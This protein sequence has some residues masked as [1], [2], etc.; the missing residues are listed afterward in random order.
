M[1]HIR[2]FS[3]IAHI[4]HGKSTLSDRLIQVCGG[5][6][7]REMAAQVLDSM[8]LERERGITIKS[9]SVTLN[10]TAKDGETYQ[11]N[12]IDTPGHV[13]FAYEVSRS[14]AACEGALLVVDAGQGVEAQTLANC[15]TAIEMDLEVVPILNKIDLP[16]AD[17]E[18][19]AEEI[20][21]IVGIDAMDATHCSAKT[22]LGVEDVLENIVSAIPAPEGDPDAPLQALIIDSWFDNYLGVVSLVRIKN[23]SLKKNDKI[24]VMS[25]GQAWG[26]DRLGIFTPKQVDTDVLNT[27]EVGWVVCG[28]KDILG[29]PVGD[30]LTLAKN[31]SD[32]PLPG[33][34]KV[35]PQVY[36]GLF[37]VSSDDYENFRDALGKLS[38]NDASLFYEPENS[39]ALGFGFRCGFLGMLHME[40]IQERLEREYDLDLI[41]T[42]PT[43]VYEVEKTD[44]E[45]LY[46][47][48]PAK[49]PA[50]ND[51]EEIR[52][53]IARCNI[54][55]PSD[56]L[57]NVITLCVEKRGLQV[58]MVY[59]G[60]QVAVTYDIPMAEVVLDFFDRLKS[61]SRGYA[62]LDYNFQRFEA[63]NMVRVDVLLNGDKVDA[64]ALIT[65]KDQSQTRGRQL[66]EKMKEFI[67]RQM[68]DIAIQAAIGNHII[69]RSTVKQLRKNVIAKCY[70]GDVSRKKKL[71]K[72]QKEGKKR[73]K[74]IGNVE[75][76]QEAFLAIL[77]VGKD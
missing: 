26:V 28:I 69:A 47:D 1:K 12:F 13:D 54:L 29:A 50:I 77:H 25:T 9:Q 55:V 56:Y 70:G 16:A 62:S 51:I 39:A 60:N 11:L 34:K 33:F 64:L 38:L 35:K 65:H 32:K 72:K 30:T 42:A 6:S 8:D 76:P 18:R 75:L 27:G 41:T 24:K 59:H 31:G 57:G 52:E 10:Y 5:L 45:L 40:I 2:N 49:L 67:P 37:P 17:P 73:M 19:V 53:P 71:L 14:L 74:Q 21:E 20:E 3:I 61:T 48:S 63:S 43:V 66:V 7:D 44:G 58:D 68:F 4:D 46:V 36:A 23:G 15:Y 22:G